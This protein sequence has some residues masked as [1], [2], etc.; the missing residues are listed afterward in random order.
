MTSRNPEPG[1][2][3]TLR[4]G[5]INLPFIMTSHRSAWRRGREREKRLEPP[6][7]PPCGEA[8]CPKAR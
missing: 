2:Y 8:A 3:L 6:F 7:Y 5:S 1:P 4:V